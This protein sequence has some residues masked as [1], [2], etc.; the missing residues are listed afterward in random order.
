MKLHP[1]YDLNLETMWRAMLALQP[2][3]HL[4]EGAA[5]IRPLWPLG[6]LEAVP[7]Q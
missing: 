6:L 1:L 2:G 3:A 4:P 5:H 7:E